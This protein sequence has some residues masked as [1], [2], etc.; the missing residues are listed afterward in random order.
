MCSTSPRVSKSKS[1]VTIASASAPK[2][3][4]IILASLGSRSSGTLIKVV[5]EEVENPLTTDQIFNCIISLLQLWLK[6]RTFECGFEF[7]Q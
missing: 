3:V 1:P 6:F 7:Q 5:E 4:S 2:A